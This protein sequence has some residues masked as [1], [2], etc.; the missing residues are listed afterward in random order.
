MV[1]IERLVIQ[2]FKSF[3]RKTSI[4]F[5]NGFSVI[6]GP[7]GSG[8]SN[9]GDAISFVL[10]RT[11]SKSLRAKRAHELIFHGSE[12]KQASEFAKVT[13]YFDNSSGLLPLEEKTVSVSRRIN[14]N[15]VSV[16]RLND[17]VVTR[18][19]LVDILAQAGIHPDG[20]NIIQQ[21]DVNKIVEMLS[22]IHI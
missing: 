13:L 17:K 7:N 21:G 3:K 9:I 2:G 15:G 22:L 20:H 5:P 16:Y 12:T 10:G 1:R 18:Q 19:Q 14:K 11:S 6:T 4:P 8:K